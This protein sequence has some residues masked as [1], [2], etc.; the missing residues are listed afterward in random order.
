VHRALLERVR[1]ANHG[2]R[3]GRARVTVK[4]TFERAG[5]SR[6]FDE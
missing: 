2:D 6:Y 4:R 5:W 3:R 1:M